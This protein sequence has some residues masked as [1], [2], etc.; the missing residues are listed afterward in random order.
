LGVIG[1][2]KKPNF[3]EEVGDYNQLSQ[4]F[5]QGHVEAIWSCFGSFLTVLESR[6]AEAKPSQGQ[7]EARKL[8]R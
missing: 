5:N 1:L 3:W 6:D 8:L 4:L 2:F 7:F